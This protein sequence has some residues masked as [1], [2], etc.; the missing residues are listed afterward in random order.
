MTW[1]PIETAPK[2]VREILLC[3]GP[4]RSFTNQIWFGH[5]NPYYFCWVMRDGDTLIDDDAPTHWMPLPE[6]PK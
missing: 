5:W 1:Q 3:L 2:T 6:P 4:E